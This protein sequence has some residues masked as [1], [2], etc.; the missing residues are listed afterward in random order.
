M[1]MN[2]FQLMVGTFHSHAHNCLFQLQWHPTYIKGTGH[3]EEEG[4][5]HVFLS[6]N[7][8]AR[9]ARHASHFHQHQMIKEHFHFWNKDKYA[10]LTNL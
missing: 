9:S 2:G 6:S 4:C 5:E 8:L 7:D 3:S 1:K 10:N